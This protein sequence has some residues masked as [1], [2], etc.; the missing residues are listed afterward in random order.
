MYMLYQIM[1]GEAFFVFD[2][3]WGTSGLELIFF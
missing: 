3:K 1:V 2:D